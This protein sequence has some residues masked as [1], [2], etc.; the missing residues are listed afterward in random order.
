MKKPLLIYFIEF[1]N[2]IFAA[3]FALMVLAS[4]YATVCYEQIGLTSPHV[5][6]AL[7][8]I[9]SISFLSSIATYVSFKSAYAKQTKPTKLTFLI[10]SILLAFEWIISIEFEVI[11][12]AF[13]G[14]FYLVG[15]VHGLAIDICLETKA[16]KNRV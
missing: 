2:A 4:L 3:M 12:L 8:F 7:D 6:Y 9:S 10:A 5:V 11:A 16:N 15:Y 1:F 13:A 14:V